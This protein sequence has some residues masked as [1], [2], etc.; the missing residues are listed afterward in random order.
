MSSKPMTYQQIRNSTAKLVYNGVTIL[1]DP[2]LAPKEFYP[3]FDMAPAPELKKK[4]LPLNDLPMTVEEVIKDIDAVIISHTHYYHWDDHAAKAIP[5]NIPIFVQDAADK[6]V[7]EKDGFTDIRVVGVNIPFKGLTITKTSGQH[8]TDEMFSNP[9]IAENFGH[10]MGF[11]FKAQGLKTVYFAGDTVWHDYV[12]V[13]INRHKPDYIVLNA[14]YCHYDGLVGSSMMGV[15]DVKKCYEFCKT[16]KI[17]TSHFDS[18]CHARYTSDMM[19]KFVEENKLQ[20][21]VFVPKDG[22]TLNL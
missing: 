10:S 11:V 8:G 17:I 2:F 15:D 21:R 3:G 13:A 12:E 16:A 9:T 7:V 18:F 6:K 1:V 20:D 14:S 5:K 4:R 19:R 22:E